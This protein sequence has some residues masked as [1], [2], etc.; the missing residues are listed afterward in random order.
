MLLINL[1][2]NKPGLVGSS[3][4]CLVEGPD[5]EGCR[6]TFLVNPS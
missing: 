5:T 2:F 4:C 1:P 6:S 3:L